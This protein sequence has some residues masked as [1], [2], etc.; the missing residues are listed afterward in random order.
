[1]PQVVAEF[2]I[3]CQSCGKGLCMNVS[4][5]PSRRSSTGNSLSIEPCERCL[6]TAEEEGFEEG[7]KAAQEEM[8]E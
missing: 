2:E 3:W 4:E 6:K 5:D 1:M 7:L 8:S